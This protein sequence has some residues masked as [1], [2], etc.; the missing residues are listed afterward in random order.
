[1]AEATVEY[2]VIG[3]RPVRP[4]GADKVTG[5]AV[6]GGDMRLTGML[7]GKVL[8]SPHAHARIKS[9]NTSKAE[10]LPGVKAVVTARDMPKA[11]ERIA[12]LGEM[13]VNVKYLSNNVLADDKVLYKGHAVAAVAA[14]SVH[15]AEEA[16]GLIDVEYEVLPP[17]LHVLEAMQEDAP[18][19]HETMTTTELGQKTDKRSNIASHYQFKLGD[20]AQGFRDAEVVIEREFNTAT[21]HQGYIEPH[22]ATALWNEDGHLY[23]WTSTQGAF[24]VQRQVAEILGLAVSQVSVTPC[25]I[26]GGFGGKISVY[27]EPVVAVLSRKAGRP[28]K[29]IMSRIEE[30]DA[31]GPTPASHIKVKMGAKKDGQIVAAE[32]SLMYEAGAFPGS[33]V[34]AGGMCIFSPYAIPNMQVDGYDVVVNKPKTAAYRAPGAT[35]AA[36]A[37]E[38]VLDELAEA[39]RLD[40]LEMRRINGAKEGDRQVHGPTYP[41]IGY[42]ETV[43][44]A[45]EHEHYHAPLEGP[46]RGRGVASGFWFNVG[47][48]STVV[49]SVNS[50]GTVSLVEGST[51]IGGTRASIAMQAAE[52]LGIPYEDV[53]PTVV[54]TDGVGYTDVTGGSRTTFATGY[55]AVEAARDVIRQM[56]ER[57]ARRWD[58]EIQKESEG[59]PESDMARISP[60]DVTYADGVFR[61]ARDAN[62]SVTFKEMA[63][64]MP[65]TGGPISGRATSQPRGVGGAFATHIVDVEV[66][67]DTGKV[68]ILR[69]T[70]VQDAGRAIHPSYVE[71]QIQGG[72]VQGIGWALNEEFVYTNNGNMVNSSFL[73][74]RMP[75]TLDLPMIDTVIV[76]VPN[77][78]HPYGVRGVG[79]VPIVPP[80]AAVANAIYRATGKRMTDLPMS[81]G[82]ILSKLQEK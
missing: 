69:Y 82:Y 44:A 54:G 13:S 23:I 58:D 22:N 4:D 61:C 75:T 9:I 35:N 65:R 50:D 37:S 20:V 26:G 55:A 34:G 80:P 12:N 7:H 79:E 78:G 48:Q 42:V 71:G 21:V 81:P 2:K 56:Q 1:M 30:F 53:R 66:D 60:E 38:T 25:E 10:A 5:R 63:T 62:K 16:L 8:R 15:I 73:D 39:L 24:V 19:L 40:P 70:A 14:T 43:H 3:T 46:N 52:T 72:V 18:L 17:A 41:R 6:Y 47:F 28:V 49:I 11:E 77:P 68:T 51:D 67:H 45:L 27:L 64:L 57:L 76:E 31:T 33:P 29:I 36:F 59:R 74:Y 32:A